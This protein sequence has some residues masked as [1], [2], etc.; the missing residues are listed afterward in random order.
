MR[1]RSLVLALAVLFLLGF[2]LVTGAGC[3]AEE[4]SPEKVA[5]AE[6]K[7]A[8]AKK[9]EKTKK[10]DDDD[11]DDDDK[12]AGDDD[13]DDDECA[14]LAAKVKALE[15][16]VVAKDAKIAE[17]TKQLAVAVL[18]TV[19]AA[20]VAAAAP[21][22]AP[23]PTAAAVPAALPTPAVVPV[24][25]PSVGTTAPATPGDPCVQLAKCCADMKS[26]VPALAQACTGIETAAAQ[27]P[28]AQKGLVCAQGMK[29]LSAAG[30]APASCK[31]T[32]VA[33]A[34]GA[35]TAPTPA[36][37]APVPA[38]PTPAAAPVPPPTPVAAPA[39]APAAADVCAKA[40]AC[41]AGVAAAMPQMAKACGAL[42]G[43]KGAQMCGAMLN[44]FKQAAGALPQMGKTVPTACQ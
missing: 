18:K 7:D 3:G 21:P 33:P 44:S 10:S 43:V 32:A 30:N 39:A 9:A 37:P 36:A 25:V 16:Q 23:S 5:K 4:A 14:A 11:D 20:P 12:Q 2:T 6:K 29:S 13:D 42:D 1:S 31:T 26:S 19:P 41:C 38:A 34:P 8:P 15:A 22:V 27:V 28:P 35:A 17:L 24:A 40:K